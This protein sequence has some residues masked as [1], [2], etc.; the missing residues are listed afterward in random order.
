MDTKHADVMKLVGRILISIIFI[1]SGYGKI[2]AFGGTAAFIASVGLPF[3]E[4]GVVIAIIVELVG[5]VML[6]F[7]YQTKLAA[8]ALGIFT[9][10]TGALFHFNLADQAQTIQ[11]MKNL[12]IV[13]GFLYIAVGGA[14]KY[15]FDAQHT[16]KS[17]PQAPVV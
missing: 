9:L 4:L 14:G 3:P 7:G 5:G 1:V 2:I 15:S 10:V 12:A 8:W 16:A 13:A 17:A 11:L 6:L